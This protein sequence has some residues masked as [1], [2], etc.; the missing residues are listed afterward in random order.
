MIGEFCPKVFALKGIRRVESGNR[1]VEPDAE[2]SARSRQRPL[3]RP[4]MHSKR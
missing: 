4:L 2:G 3:K 1:I